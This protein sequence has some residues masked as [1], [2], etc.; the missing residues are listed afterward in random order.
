MQNYIVGL[1]SY[2]FKKGDT[3]QIFLVIEEWFKHPDNPNKEGISFALILDSIYLLKSIKA[4]FVKVIIKSISQI[5]LVYGPIEF[6]ISL[7]NFKMNFFDCIYFLLEDIE[8]ECQK[9]GSLSSEKYK[10]L[11]SYFDE[12]SVNEFIE[13]SIVRENLFIENVKIIFLLI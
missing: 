6:E 8:I 13:K 4:L 5:R 2:Y 9:Q 11:T 1:Y 3:D 12:D 10:Y 7:E